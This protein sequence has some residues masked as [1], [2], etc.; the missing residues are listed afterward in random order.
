MV[1]VPAGD[2]VTVP[3]VRNFGFAA[4][5]VATIARLAIN[6]STTDRRRMG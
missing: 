1:K 4:D 3:K 6:A 2:S 5:T